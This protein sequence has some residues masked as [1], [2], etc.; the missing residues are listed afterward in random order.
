MRYNYPGL[1]DFEM[2]IHP[3]AART[4]RFEIHSQSELITA[5]SGRDDFMFTA[6]NGIRII[7]RGHIEL[8][9]ETV[10]LLGE[11]KDYRKA[12]TKNYRDVLEAQGRL[13][14]YLEAFDELAK[15]KGIRLQGTVA[16]PEQLSLWGDDAI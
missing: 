15:S 2:D 14:Q 5:A 9:G 1:I 16:E 12:T 6:S 7:S 3:D 8:F 13:I 10:F 11:S 4:I